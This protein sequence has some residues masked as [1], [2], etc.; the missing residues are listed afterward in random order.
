MKIIVTGAGGRL[1]R[2][3]VA[4]LTPQHTVIGLT[5]EQLDISQFHQVRQ[6]I[7]AE[8]PDV[9]LNAAAWTDV[10]GCAR[11]PQKALQING[12]GAHNLAVATADV[13][14]IIMHISTNEVFDGESRRPYLEYDRTSAI[15]AYGYSKWYAEQAIL[16][17]NAKHIIVRTAWLFAHGGRNFIHAILDAARSGKALRVVTDE[18][19]NPTYTDDLA[20]AIST[21]LQMRRYGIYHCVNEGFC[22]RYQFARYVLDRAGYAHIPIEP[23]TRHEWPRPSTPPLYSALDNMA[24]KYLGVQLRPWQEAV[25]AFLDREGWLV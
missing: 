2:L 8:R 17:I 22:S 21:L 5:K 14:A 18:V 23:I 7:E 10:D 24:A 6:K 25:D 11:E 15:N 13:N 3:L 12:I 20:I 4:N 16:H 19:A 9:V 1:G